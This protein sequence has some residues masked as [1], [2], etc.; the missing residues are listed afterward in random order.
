MCY[1]ELCIQD[2]KLNHI[3]AGYL[4]EGRYFGAIMGNAKIARIECL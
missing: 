4:F 1:F 3:E 2:I